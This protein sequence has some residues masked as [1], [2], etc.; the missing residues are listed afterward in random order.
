[1]YGEGEEEAAP[2]DG[3]GALRDARREHAPTDHRAAGADGVAQHAAHRHAQ[4]VHVSRKLMGGEKEGGGGGG[5]VRKGVGGKE[6]FL[7]E[8]P[9]LP[10]KRAQ[11]RHGPERDESVKEGY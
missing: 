7:R 8:P 9:P 3:H 4:R 2:R 5:E 1:M 6:A 10:P 11:L